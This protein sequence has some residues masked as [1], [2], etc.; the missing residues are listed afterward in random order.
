MGDIMPNKDKYYLVEASALPSVF[1]KVI[2]TNR[3]LQLGKA[4]TVN[5]AVLKTGISRSAYYKYKDSISPFYEVAKER[6]ITISAV[7]R[8]EPGILSNLLNVFA[9]AGTNIL[10][11]NQSIPINGIAGVTLSIQTGHMKIK[12]ESLL[13]RM[14]AQDGVVKMEIVASE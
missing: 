8:D 12:L 2:E 14:R 1:L 4:K 13:E 6:I 7:L 11:I 5:E 9:K 3:L 10:T